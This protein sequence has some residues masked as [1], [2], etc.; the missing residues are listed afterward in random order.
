M[1]RIIVF[2]LLC[3][4]GYEIFSQTG[5]Y[6]VQTVESTLGVDTIHYYIGQDFFFGRRQFPSMANLNAM[7][8]YFFVD[9]KSGKK[10]EYYIPRSENK[11]SIYSPD[12]LDFI[13]IVLDSVYNENGNIDNEFF[14]I[15]NNRYVNSKKMDTVYVVSCMD[16]PQMENVF[17]Y[18]NISTKNCI[19]TLS[20]GQK[21]PITIATD[22][23]MPSVVSEVA[24]FT[25][26]ETQIGN[27]ILDATT[28]KVK[29]KTVFIQEFTIKERDKQRLLSA[30]YDAEIIGMIQHILGLYVPHLHI[31]RKD[32]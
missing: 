8:S 5:H 29:R 1:K 20:T 31:P 7:D 13:N 30:E 2:C 26:S 24:S 6:V 32:K 3:L 12:F 21:I 10:K 4:F 14:F 25:R 22:I 28:E 17:S 9:F 19:I 23:A 18:I 16:A 27:A 15:E 11:I